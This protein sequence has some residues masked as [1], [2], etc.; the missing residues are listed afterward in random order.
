NQ[1]LQSEVAERARA[2]EALKA[3]DRHKDEFLAI[4][5]HELRNPL[6]PIL[7]AVQLMGR[8]SLSDP[9]LIWSQEV[10]ER[11]AGHLARLVD[12]LLDVSRITRG[13][14][15][16]SREPITLG[17]LVSQAVETVQPLLTEREHQFRIEVPPGPLWVNGDP[18][19]LTQA[20]GNVLGNAAKYTESR[21][22][23]SLVA[24]Q[25]AGQAEIVIT[26]NGI[27]IPTALLPRIFDMFTQL[28]HRTESAH[29]GL[30]I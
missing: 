12:D 26:D 18:L 11:Q 19:R 15:N 20:I 4:L 30:G 5:A 27:G 21:G 23:I 28:N 2:E 10:I 8:K 17:T 22:R 9:Q 6:A 1:T 24:R 16:L 3:A 14:V 25:S 29:G 13:K 7:N